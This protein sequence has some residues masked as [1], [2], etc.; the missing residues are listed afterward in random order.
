[1][2]AALQT[3]TMGVTPVQHD[4]DLYAQWAAGERKAGETLIERHLDTVGRFLANKCPDPSRLE[5]LVATVF[6]R[7]AKSLGRFGGRS[8]FRTYLLGI[9]YNVARDDLKRHVRSPK[10]DET[11]TSIASISSSPSAIVAVRE[12]QAMLLQALRQLPFALQAVLELHYFEEMSRAEVAQVLELPEGTVASRL[13]KAKAELRTELEALADN[14]ELREA[15]VTDL[16][17][18]V[19]D[20]RTRL[21][22]P[23]N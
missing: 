5:D 20:L 10:F 18:W 16:A 19:A 8:S 21:S 6:E 7:C 2:T 15:T 11:L 13:R 4:E 12:E 23:E 17:S 9:A 1:M 14:P 3:R 22:G